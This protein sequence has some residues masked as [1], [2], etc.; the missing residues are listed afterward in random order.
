MTFCA[1]TTAIPENA[2]TPAAQ[3]IG[4]RFLKLRLDGSECHQIAACCSACESG[5]PVWIRR[6]VVVGK[7]D[8]CVTGFGYAAIAGPR[9]TGQRFMG[10]ANEVRR[11]RQG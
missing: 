9:N 6:F 7:D 8:A 2:H 5:K 11:R 1:A 10:I 3:S 4:R